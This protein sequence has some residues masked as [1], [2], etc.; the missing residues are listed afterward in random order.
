M[1]QEGE[2]EEEEQQQQEEKK[3]KKK[4]KKKNT[5]NDAA[6]G[7]NEERARCG[8]P[9]CVLELGRVG[10]AATAAPAGGGPSPSAR[11]HNTTEQRVSVQHMPVNSAQHRRAYSERAREC[12]C[13]A[14]ACVRV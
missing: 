8:V 12:L 14:C 2:E 3:T 5:I 13:V 11:Q 1:E 10:G 6:E 4:K 7:D 9:G